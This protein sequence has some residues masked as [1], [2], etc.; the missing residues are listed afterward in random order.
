MPLAL[1][2]D[3]PLAL[4]PDLPPAQGCSQVCRQDCRQDYCQDCRQDCRQNCRQNCLLP[5]I[6]HC[7]QATCVQVLSLGNHGK[8]LE[9]GLVCRSRSSKS[10]SYSRLLLCAPCYVAELLN[11]CYGCH[12]SSFPLPHNI[13]KSTTAR[14]LHV[15]SPPCF[16]N[17][18]ATTPLYHG[19][20]IFWPLVTSCGL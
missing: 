13:Y 3:V 5:L 1:Q 14:P 2:P 19:L 12:G 18:T 7:T 17:H 6:P 15:P 16:L 20:S 4:Q 11:G 9:K 10:V 8:L